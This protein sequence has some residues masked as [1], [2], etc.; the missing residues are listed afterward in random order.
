[1][2]FWLF[3]KLFDE[4]C[5]LLIKHSLSI[6]IKS[7]FFVVVSC[8]FSREA[9]TDFSQARPIVNRKVFKKVTR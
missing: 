5:L 4:N 3:L 9:G 2:V 1:L 6:G 7:W 8:C